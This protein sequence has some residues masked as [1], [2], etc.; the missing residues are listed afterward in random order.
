MIAALAPRLDVGFV[1]RATMSMRTQ[2]RYVERL[3]VNLPAAALA[4]A[5][6]V[7]TGEDVLAKGRRV[8]LAWTVV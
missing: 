7:G 3:Q 4:L 1:Q 6:A 8:L 2:V 5:V